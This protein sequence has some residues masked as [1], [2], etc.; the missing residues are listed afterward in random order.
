MKVWCV[1]VI[2]KRSEAERMVVS[3]GNR[4]DVSPSVDEREQDVGSGLVGGTA[5]VRSRCELCNDEWGHCRNC[6]RCSFYLP[7]NGLCKH[8][9]PSPL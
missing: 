4:E 3:A 6:N 9:Q 7:K 2:Q 1:G 8:C 5:T